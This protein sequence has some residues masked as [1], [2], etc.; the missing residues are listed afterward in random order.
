MAIAH[1]SPKLT[2]KFYLLSRNA[3]NPSLAGRNRGNRGF[4]LLHSLAPVQICFSAPV[5]LTALIAGT[6]VNSALAGGIVGAPTP[7]DK[8]GVKIPL[9]QHAAE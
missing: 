7:F 9:F 4:S 3:N 5:V 2:M 1:Q 6:L 8:A